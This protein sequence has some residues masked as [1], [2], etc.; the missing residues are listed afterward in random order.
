VIIVIERLKRLTHAS[1]PGAGILCD[2]A[3]RRASVDGSH[4]GTHLESM[5]R[6]TAT[7]RHPEPG[8]WPTC[9]DC[10]ERLALLYETAERGA[11][12]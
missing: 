10:A 1:L 4:L 5:R 3:R 8:E 7:W 11:A 9:Q 2:L 12:A 6:I